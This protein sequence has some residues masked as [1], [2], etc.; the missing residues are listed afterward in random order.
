MGS[1]TVNKAK[2]EKSTGPLDPIETVITINERSGFR[3]DSSE[4][5]VTLDNIGVA[6][7]QPDTDEALQKFP[8]SRHASSS[9]VITRQQLRRPSLSTDH[10]N[11]LNTLRKWLEEELEPSQNDLHAF[12]SKMR[13]P[14]FPTTD[15]L[16]QAAHT[17][18]PPRPS[19]KAFVCDVYQDRSVYHEVELGDIETCM[20]IVPRSSKYTLLI[21]E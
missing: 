16:L 1:I 6:A 17:Y 2:E 15:Q 11:T 12:I 18:Y 21:I 13:C 19:L 7:Y 9:S 3:M 20:F 5:A 8:T 14:P 10:H 4:T